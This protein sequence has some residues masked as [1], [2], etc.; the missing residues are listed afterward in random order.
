MV[1]AGD[2]N[3]ASASDS[4]CISDGASNSNSDDNINSDNNGNGDSNSNSNSNCDGKHSN[5]SDSAGN[6]AGS[7][8]NWQVGT[9]SAK[10]R[11]HADNA[12]V[13]YSSQ[14]RLVGWDDLVGLSVNSCRR[15]VR[16]RRGLDR[17]RL[18]ERWALP[19]LRDFCALRRVILGP[20]AEVRRGDG[21]ALD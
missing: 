7:S 14:S 5:D 10:R 12:F 3:G 4:A 15:C 9:G 16:S 6:G 17:F 2:S 18:L 19:L 1:P 8:N 21:D 11:W 13:V 20:V